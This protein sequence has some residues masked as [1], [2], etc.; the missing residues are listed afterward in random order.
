MF[1]NFKPRFSFYSNRS[2]LFGSDEAY[3]PL[4]YNSY[5]RTFITPLKDN[6]KLAIA[7]H[8]KD[9]VLNISTDYIHLTN[10]S[11]INPWDCSQNDIFQYVEVKQSQIIHIPPYC[12]YSIQMSKDS[13]TYI[14]SY[15]TPINI[16]SNIPGNT[17]HFLQKANL[18]SIV[19]K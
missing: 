2:I 13:I 17:M 5:T 6:V 10:C 8:C 3:T 4:Q 16:L 11:P 18:N 19:L 12:P 7:N 15:Q 9:D 14:V 1:S